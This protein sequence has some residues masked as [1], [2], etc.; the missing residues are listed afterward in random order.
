MATPLAASSALASEGAALLRA[1]AGERFGIKPD[2]RVGVFGV[3]VGEVEGDTGI[4]GGGRDGSGVADLEGS[5]G[6]GGGEHGEEGGEHEEGAEFHGGRTKTE[7]GC[8]RKPTTGFGAKE[9]RRVA[10]SEGRG[11]VSA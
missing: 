2:E 1:A 7:S 9:R 4:G 10:R 5:G 11:C 8:F 6:S 3:D